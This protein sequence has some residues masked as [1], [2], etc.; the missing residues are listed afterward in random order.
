MS[1]KAYSTDFD[2]SYEMGEFNNAADAVE[3]YFGEE[4]IVYGSEEGCI[5]FIPRNVVESCIEDWKVMDSASV[6][7][8]S[9][10]TGNTFDA[11]TC[12][13]FFEHCLNHQKG[14][15]IRLYWI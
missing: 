8:E 3:D 1:F 4:A 12:I 6:V 11:A 13:E 5:M 14:S 2:I 10:V 7:M 15:I 9:S